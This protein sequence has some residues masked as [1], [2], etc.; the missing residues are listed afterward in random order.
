MPLGIGVS[1]LELFDE[2]LKSL[3]GRSDALL[4]R[5]EFRLPL[6]RLLHVEHQ[7]ARELRGVDSTVLAEERA[8]VLLRRVEKL[9]GTLRAEMEKCEGLASKLCST[10]S[11]SNA[12]IR[13]LIGAP[14]PLERAQD[15]A[16]RGSESDVNVKN[17][18]VRNAALLQL[19]QLAEDLGCG[20]RKV[21]IPTARALVDKGSAIRDLRI[22]LRE[23]TTGTAVPVTLQA[24]VSSAILYSQSVSS[25]NG[26]GDFDACAGDFD[27]EEFAHS[28]W[29]P[30]TSY[31]E[32]LAASCVWRSVAIT[33]SAQILHWLYYDTDKSPLFN[34]IDSMLPRR[35]VAEFKA[36]LLAIL[37]SRVS[38][39]QSC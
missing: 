12:A 13:N 35:F 2:T 18:A 39:Y 10:C 4:L 11:I 24:D 30:T 17:T 16:Y 36:E 25:Q 29:K 31:D 22:V 33:S 20:R 7:A 34:E 19:L 3:R 8:Q 5:T 32:L 38:D 15:S 26:D 37:L 1:V 6:M 28:W 27:V 23:R 14:V 9:T 21:K